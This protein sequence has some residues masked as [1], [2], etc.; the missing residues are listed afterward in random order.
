[1][2]AAQDPHQVGQQLPVQA[3]GLRAVPALAGPVRNLRPGCQGLAVVGSLEALAK[4]QLVPAMLECA[5]VIAERVV[6]SS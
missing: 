2:A 6:V 5:P 4:R 1:M 3:Q